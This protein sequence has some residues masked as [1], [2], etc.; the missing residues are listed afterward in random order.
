M[1]CSSDRTVQEK[2]PKSQPC[3]VRILDLNNTNNKKNGS[4]GPGPILDCS[5]TR[6]QDLFFPINGLTFTRLRTR[7]N[8][9]TSVTAD[10]N[11]SHSGYK[12]V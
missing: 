12:S 2:F 5:L 6:Q 7:Q 1:A 10:G 8:I 11:F 3:R 4:L 9:F